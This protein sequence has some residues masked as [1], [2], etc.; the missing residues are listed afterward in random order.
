[1]VSDVSFVLV[2]CSFY[3]LCM[4]DLGQ[5]LIVYPEGLAELYI[6]SF[7]STLFFMLFD[8]CFSFLLFVI[9]FILKSTFNLKLLLTTDTVIINYDLTYSKEHTGKWRENGKAGRKAR[10]NTELMPSG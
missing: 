9:L 8:C 4:Q 6:T 3:A 7:W 10:A 1:M 2:S 5:S